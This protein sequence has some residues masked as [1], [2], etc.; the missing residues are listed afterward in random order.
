V[1]DLL[2]IS[3]LLAGQAPQA[4]STVRGATDTSQAT[5]LR[6]LAAAFWKA[7]RETKAGKTVARKDGVLTMDE[8]IYIALTFGAYFHGR[9][10]ARD[11]EADWGRRGEAELS[12]MGSDEDKAKIS[13]DC[14]LIMIRVNQAARRHDDLPR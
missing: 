13:E 14:R 3:L 7:E 11:P 1:L 4:P 6:C 12:A 9:L 5:D 2:V 10:T 8:E